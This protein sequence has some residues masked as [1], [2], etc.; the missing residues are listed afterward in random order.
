[1]RHQI[2]HKDGTVD[3]IRRSSFAD[4]LYSK[5][6][7]T[8][9]VSHRMEPVIS[10]IFTL[11]VSCPGKPLVIPNKLYC[12]SR[13][14]LIFYR[15]INCERESVLSTILSNIFEF[16]YILLFDHERAIDYETDSDR[17]WRRNH[18]SWTD[19]LSAWIIKIICFDSRHQLWR[20][21]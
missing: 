3:T 6:S 19:R 9:I 4:W 2:V 15:W 20:S 11:S 8:P 13:S 5:R 18:V 12:I 16:V 10:R 21:T 14:E 17:T 7:S 1:M